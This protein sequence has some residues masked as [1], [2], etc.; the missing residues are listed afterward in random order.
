MATAVGTY[1]TLAN[2]KLRI[3]DADT[4][5][6]TLLQSFCDQANMWVESKTQRILAPYTA[7]STTVSSGFGAGTSAGG[8]ATATGLNVNDVLCFDALGASTRESAQVAAINGTTVTLAT[9]LTFSHSGSVKRVF[10]FDGFDALENGKLL[11]MPLGLVAVTSLEVCTFSAGSGGALAPNVIFYTIPNADY[12][13]RPV[14][15][16]R[17]PGWPAT[18]LWIT[19]V[20]TPSDT[21]PSFYPGYNNIRLDCTPYWPAIPDDVIPVAEQVAVSLYRSRGS[22]GGQTINI[23]TDGTQTIERALSSI[24]WQTINRYRVR[25]IGV[26]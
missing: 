22:Q 1:A 23:G 20:P 17:S 24:D 25:Q 5:D 9:S 19:N 7:F 3:Q 10:V 2:V 13:L 21:T 6:D 26:L 15:S 8:L 4:N 11:P 12:F 18:E 16:Q 14:L